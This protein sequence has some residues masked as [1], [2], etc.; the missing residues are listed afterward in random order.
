[1]MNPD[2]TTAQSAKKSKLNRDLRDMEKDDLCIR[3][4]SWAPENSRV[5]ILNHIECTFTRGVFYGII[6]PNGS[7]KTSLVRHILRFIDVQEGQ[8]TLEGKEISEYRRSELAGKIAFVPQN[9]QIDVSFT[10]YD[11]VMMGRTPHQDRFAAANEIDRRA[12]QDAME[13]TD[14]AYLK[15]REYP[16]LSGGE[17]QRVIMARAIAQDAP[18]L[19]LDEPVSNLD[20]RHQY[21]MMDTLTMLH[22]KHGRTILAVLHDINLAA[23]YCERIVLMKDG[24]IFAE[25]KTEDTLT[26]NNLKAVYEM[27]FTAIQHPR[28]GKP[29]F[30]PER[31]SI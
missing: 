15:D 30:I 16:L 7:G 14:C 1:M 6:G 13:H 12:V 18:W 4:L 17:A 26:L 9:S 31:T 28:T 20:V 27:D 8:I 29:Y 25:G 24:R 5:S 11:I 19:I 2:R 22:Q 23:L 3:N 21:K 10:V